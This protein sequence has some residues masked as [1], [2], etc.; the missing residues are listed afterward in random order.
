MAVSYTTSGVALATLTN[1]E[2]TITFGG[3]QTLL[4]VCTLNNSTEATAE[5]EMISS[6]GQ[7]T[8]GDG[9]KH[10]TFVS[11]LPGDYY[12]TVLHGVVNDTSEALEFRPEL[13]MGADIKASFSFLY[14][15]IEFSL[16]AI[17]SLADTRVMLPG[18][19]NQVWA[20]SQIPTTESKWSHPGLQW[21]GGEDPLNPSGDTLNLNTTT[22]PKDGARAGSATFTGCIAI[23]NKST[24][25]GCVFRTTDIQGRG[26]V[27]SIQRDA[28]TDQL[29]VR[30]RFIPIDSSKGVNGASDEDFNYAFALHPFL[31]PDP[32]TAWY[33][34]LRY[35]ADQMVAESHP[36][37]S[38]GKIVD[39]PSSGSDYYP[40]KARN[41]SAFGAMTAGGNAPDGFDYGLYQTNASNLVSAFSIDA[42]ELGMSMYDFWT[43]TIGD[44][45]PVI[46]YQSGAT[47]AIQAIHD[48]GVSVWMYTIPI[49]SGLWDGSTGLPA[50]LGIN[51]DLSLDRSGN[52]IV[53]ETPIVGA[54]SG[55]AVY[56]HP[57]LLSPTNNAE[58]YDYIITEITDGIGTKF[59]GVYSDAFNAYCPPPNDD[60]G[61]TS[62]DRGVG[63]KTWWPAARAALD[64]YRTRLESAGLTAPVVF[65]EHPNEHSV[66]F[67]DFCFQNMVGPGLTSV[68][69]DASFDYVT[70]RVPNLSIGF[71]EYVGITDF[72]SFGDGPDGIISP[73]SGWASEA[74]FFNFLYS[75][76]FHNHQ[77]PSF[78]RYFGNSLN[79]YCPAD[80]D[81]EYDDWID[82]IDRMFFENKTA[83]RHWNRCKKL[84]DLPSAQHS[85]MIDAVIANDV[86]EVLVAA[87]KMHTSVAYD[88]AA[89]ELIVRIS[90]WSMTGYNP[91]TVALSATITEAKWPEFGSAARDVYLW[92][93]KT[94]AKMRMQDRT[95]AQSYA[96][97]LSIPSGFVGAVIFTPD[98][99]DPSFMG[100]VAPDFIDITG[101]QAGT[102]S[103]TG[104][105]A[106]TISITGDLL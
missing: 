50:A 29:I 98:G 84:R 42:G 43:G 47:A 65:A 64:L 67:T 101:D 37:I 11:S 75:Y 89:D 20:L 80:R 54:D 6:T 3:T 48:T 59:S 24:G 62:N 46:N 9:S 10:T 72:G 23:W 12:T 17:G 74:E 73:I 56:I 83:V 21:L 8:D 1:S 61:L 41:M 97:S 82:F 76:N 77:I 104:D 90:N 78:L 106:G 27:F 34:A 49:S 96:L 57:N 15:S 99:V 68:T 93:W 39:R 14:A 95:A 44:E 18:P 69:G 55:G 25:V 4:R 81:A 22:I 31:S 2:A 28:V 88:T 45:F 30:C 79:V 60:S 40:A 86:T 92:N 38:K 87:A 105:L 26:K 35:H 52:P 70:N 53:G 13:T 33:D 85:R 102:I 36:A 16:P 5:E 66:G 94:G 71:S 19:I 91:E 32:E 58:L 100:T 63:S 7:V 51:N 103:T